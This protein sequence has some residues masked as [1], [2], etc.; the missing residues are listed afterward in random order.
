MKDKMF[1]TICIVLLILIL[2]LVIWY[3]IKLH[4]E[5]TKVNQYKQ[6]NEI[7]LD[8]AIDYLGAEVENCYMILMDFRDT[9]ELK[10]MFDEV[11]AKHKVEI[12]IVFPDTVVEMTYRDFRNRI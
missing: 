12:R 1:S 10:D 4:S 6:Y 3:A 8:S 9:R 11:M 5:L 2:L 7:E